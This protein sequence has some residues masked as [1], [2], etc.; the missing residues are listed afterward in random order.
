[1][2]NHGGQQTWNQSRLTFV[3]NY[4][5]ADWFEGKSVLEVAAGHGQI[6]DALANLGSRVISTDARAVHVDAI[7]ERG[8]IAYIMNQEEPWTIDGYFDLIIHW[9]VL[10]HLDHWKEDLREALLRTKMLCL[11]TEIFPSDDPTFEHKRDEP[12][13]QYDQSFSGKGTQPS[14]EHVE[15][16]LVEN[17]ASYMRYDLPE[18]NAGPMQYDWDLKQYMEKGVPGQTVPRRF[19]MIRSDRNEIVDSYI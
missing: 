17:G 10:Y 3:L 9:G 14:A 8:R 1:M 13:T 12:S 19:W 18:L 6:G 11:E 2:F 4:F 5:G 15:A 7:K 16:W